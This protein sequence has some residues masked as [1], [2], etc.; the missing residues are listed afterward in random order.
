MFIP[1]NPEPRNLHHSTLTA[2]RRPSAA[3]DRYAFKPGEAL[4]RV[5][6]CGWPGFE[7]G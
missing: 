2:K 1:S 7:G 4:R 6:D 3:V 5:W